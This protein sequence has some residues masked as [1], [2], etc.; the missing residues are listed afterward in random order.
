MS[1]SQAAAVHDRPSK[2]T[3]FCV[4]LTF[5][6]SCHHDIMWQFGKAV[7]FTCSVLAAG[8]TFCHSGESL[9]SSGSN[10]I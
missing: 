3:L 9:Y 5:L 7:L 2:E 6:Q 8:E 1:A 4:L 10:Y